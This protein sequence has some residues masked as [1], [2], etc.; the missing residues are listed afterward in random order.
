MKINIFQLVKENITTKDAVIH[1]GM[2][3]NKSGLICCPFHH[4]KNPSMKVDRRYYCFGCG[5]S[6]DVIDFT[7][8][9][10]NLSVKDAARKLADDFG[11]VI[12]ENF[13]VPSSR[14]SIWRVPINPSVSNA[15]EYPIREITKAFR[16][17]ADYSNLLREWKKNYAPKT[18]DEEWNEHFIE[19]L[20][21]LTWTEY[22]A[23]G[24][25]FGSKEENKEFYEFYKEEV[26]RIG[27]R[28]IVIDQAT[29][30]GMLNNK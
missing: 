18:M 9:Y 4:D 30:S 15:Q 19:S 1:Y 29:D 16:I 17:V 11:L 27:E 26:S 2:H 7:K 10:F 23:D 14:K 28:V 24:L 3:P 12:E 20:D 5:A 13:T 22:L 21:K 25:L 8:Q 6:G